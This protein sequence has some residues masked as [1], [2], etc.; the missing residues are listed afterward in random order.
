[1]SPKRYSDNVIPLGG[2]FHILEI[3]Y[4]C[5]ADDPQVSNPLKQGTKI[6]YTVPYIV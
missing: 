4:H 5:Y 6:R 2:L 1:M 3:V